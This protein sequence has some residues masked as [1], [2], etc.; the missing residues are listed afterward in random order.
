[1]KVRKVEIKLSLC[2]S[3]IITHTEN[4]NRYTEDLL[5]LM[6]LVVRLLGIINTI[7]K[8]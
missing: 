5:E 7:F 1:M 6:N 8:N 3:N 2:T 4:P